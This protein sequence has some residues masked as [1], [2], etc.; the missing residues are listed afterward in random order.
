MSLFDSKKETWNR[1]LSSQFTEVHSDVLDYYVES[2][3]SFDEAFSLAEDAQVKSLNSKALYDGSFE[4]D[5]QQYE[6]LHAYR[7]SVVMDQNSFSTSLDYVEY[8]GHRLKEKFLNVFG[9]DDEVLRSD[10]DQAK[11]SF[12]KRYGDFGY[13]YPSFSDW[14]EIDRTPIDMPEKEID[15]PR[16]MQDQYGSYTIFNIERSDMSESSDEE[17]LEMKK[18]LDPMDVGFGHFI[19]NQYEDFVPL[20]QDANDEET[21]YD[22][23]VKM[24]DEFGWPERSNLMND[25]ERMEDD[26]E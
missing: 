13:I 25:L 8:V 9:E 12:E 26:F 17:F 4:F 20:L 14:L 16:S 11:E 15:L 19:H 7:L 23:F 6:S 21:L 22:G 2:S 18:I 24:N 3:D 5:Q 10:Y 1:R